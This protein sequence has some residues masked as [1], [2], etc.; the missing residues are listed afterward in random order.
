MR[1][2]W[3]AA[4]SFAIGVAFWPG[5]AGASISPRWALI[6]AGVW[7]F[8]RPVEVTAGHFT[9]A[10]LLAWSAVTLTWSPFP[11]DGIDALAQL[12]FLAGA[13]WVGS[14]LTNLRPIYAGFVLALGVSS[15]AAIAQA[16]WGWDGVF[17]STQGAAGLFVNKNTMAEIATLVLIGVMVERMWWA[18]P[19]VLPA[20]F[21]P[22]SRG[23]L[24]ALAVAVVVHLR[25][26]PLVWFTMAMV[27]G[28]IGVLVFD[29]EIIPAIPNSVYERLSFWS[30]TVRHLNLM[31]HGLGSFNGLYP[32][33][34]TADTLA[35]RTDHVHNDYLEWLFELG[36]IGAALL[37]A[38]VVVGFRSNGGAAER[39]VAIALGV[40][41]L[42]AF[43]LHLPC[44]A[45]MGALVLGNL[46]GAGDRVRGRV[47]AGGGVLP[48]RHRPQSNRIG[49]DGGAGV[50]VSPLSSHRSCL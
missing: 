42:F 24:L 9:M 49:L 33:F 32:S 23:A 19:L 15:V 8:V 21:M 45:F 29:L 43:P 18:V 46:C 40:E 26:E 11:L 17:Q 5:T 37:A 41:M 39:C 25:R 50:P 16:V 2:V 48:G 44:T 34:A 31:G 4:Y 22:L 30:D 20:A 36:V 28:G 10:L 14:S 3:L 47:A 6:G 1:D 13:F 38:L 7:F 35:V 27:A 12:I